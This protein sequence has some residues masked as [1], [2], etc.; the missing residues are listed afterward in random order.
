MTNQVVTMASVND[1]VLDG[2][3]SE[4]LAEV[5]FNPKGD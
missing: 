1:Y 4:T 2:Q 3:F 5:F